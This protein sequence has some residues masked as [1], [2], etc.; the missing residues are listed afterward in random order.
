MV[1]H[2]FFAL[3]SIFFLN[4][5]LA[6]DKSLKN[7]GSA[8]DADRAVQGERLQGNVI[9][10]AEVFSQ[11]KETSEG[12]SADNQDGR[13]Q[14]GMNTAGGAKQQRLP[15]AT[16]IIITGDRPVSGGS[17]RKTFSGSGAIGEGHTS[18]EGSNATFGNS[19]R[20]RRPPANTGTIKMRYKEKAGKTGKKYSK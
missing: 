13:A 15:N 14:E 6:R 16:G 8:A 18:K 1:L 10:S 20:G 3:G 17:D 7:R 11:K 19:E 12:L 4:L 9:G 5:T 2:L